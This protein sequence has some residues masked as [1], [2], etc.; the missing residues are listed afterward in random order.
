MTV[1]TVNYRESIAQDLVDTLK[2]MQDP[3][4]VLVTREPFEVE[5]LALTQ[6]PAILIATSN[7]IREDYAM[8]SRQGSIDYTV[9]AFVRGGGQVLDRLKNDIIE[10]IEESVESDRRR[11]TNNYSVSTQVVQILIPERLAPLAEVVLTVRVRY[12]YSRGVT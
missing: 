4:P 7:E 10:R 6:F 9:R 3:K 5:K 12:K 2:N 8:G 1:E 11:N